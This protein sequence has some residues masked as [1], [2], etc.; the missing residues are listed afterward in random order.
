MISSPTNN[1]KQPQIDYGKIYSVSRLAMF[2]KCQT[3][4]DYSYQHD[5]YKKLKNKLKNLF[6]VYQADKKCQSISV[7]Y[8]PKFIE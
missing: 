6:S 3:Q 8:K 4:Y 1:L 2:D 5:I 7:A